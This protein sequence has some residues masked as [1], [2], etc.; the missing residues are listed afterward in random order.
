MDGQLVDLY[1]VFFTHHTGRF[2]CAGKICYWFY[3]YPE[4]SLVRF[5]YNFNYPWG[6]DILRKIRGW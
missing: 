5:F 1:M 2:E 4:F 6:V 3:P